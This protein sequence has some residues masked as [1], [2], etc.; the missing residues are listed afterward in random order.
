MM[1]V[2]QTLSSLGERG[3]LIANAEALEAIDM[4]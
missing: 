3:A 2:F 4:A 1:V